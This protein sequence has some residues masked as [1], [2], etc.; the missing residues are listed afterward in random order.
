MG[1]QTVNCSSR[2]TPKR[3]DMNTLLVLLPSWHV[4]WPLTMGTMGT[5]DTMVMDTATSTSANTMAIMDTMDMGIMVMDI[6][7]TTVMVMDIT[8]I[9]GMVMDMVTVTMDIMESTNVKLTLHQKH[10]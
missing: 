10:P 2:L 1:Q 6:M 4:Q 7:D 9:M 5:T 3:S 8:V